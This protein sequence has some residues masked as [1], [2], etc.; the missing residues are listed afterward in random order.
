MSSSWIQP[1]RRQLSSLA[2]LS[3]SIFSQTAA[4]T[5]IDSWFR[6][7][8]R[9]FGKSARCSSARSSGRSKL[10]RCELLELRPACRD[11]GIPATIE[12]GPG[13]QKRPAV[14]KAVEHRPVRVCHDDETHSGML[15][16]KIGRPAALR[17]CGSVQH[18]SIL[19]IVGQVTREEIGDP[20]A[21]RGMQEAKHRDGERVSCET[22]HQGPSPVLLCQ[23]VSMD[24][25]GTPAAEI[26]LGFTAEEVDAQFMAE[27][28]S[29]PAVMIAT[30]ESDRNAAGPYLLQLR[31]CGKVFAG[32][33]ALVLEP[34]VEQISRE[35]EVI[36]DLRYCFEEG[37]KCGPDARGD[38]TE[39][40]VR[41][42]EDARNR[43]GHGP[44]LESW[45]QC[46]KPI[47]V[48]SR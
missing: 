30:H 10:F 47:R 37:V 21:D 44:S 9:I 33:D 5:I 40:G 4:V 6:T 39:V 34:E 32:Y 20:E 48:Y 36:A 28:C 2:S 46:R 26:E 12:E 43:D 42:N 41:H 13:S 31:D 27:E 35:H 16:E 38:L 1:R 24:D 11:L 14:G 45:N 29:A 15:D 23:P 8:N 22:V 3:D 19:C 25:V 7:T 18:R 17:R